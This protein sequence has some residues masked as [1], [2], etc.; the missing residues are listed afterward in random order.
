MIITILKIFHDLFWSLAIYF[1]VFEWVSIYILIKYEEKASIDQIIYRNKETMNDSIKKFNE[2]EVKAK[3][4]FIASIIAI[5]S[6]Y[7]YIV[8]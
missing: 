7:Y 4:I 3:K 6:F 8:F 1:Q 2:F 5:K